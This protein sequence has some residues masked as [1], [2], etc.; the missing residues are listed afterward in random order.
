MRSG[1]PTSATR[2]WS[3]VP[4]TRFGEAVGRRRPPR[5]GNGRDARPAAGPL[6][7]PAGPLQAA[8]PT[9]GGGG[10]PPPRHR[11]GG[12]APRRAACSPRPGPPESA[13][14]PRPGPHPPAGSRSRTVGQQSPATLTSDARLR[15]SAAGG[16][17]R[18]AGPRGAADGRSQGGCRA[19]D[20][21]P[22]RA[23]LRPAQPGAHVPPRR[24][25]AA[26]DGAVARAAPRG[27][28]RRRGL[29]HRRPVPGPGR[30]RA[31]A[32]RHRPV[33]GDAAH[34]RTGAP[35]VQA[36]GLRL[37]LGGRLGRRPH[38]RF[39]PAQ[40]RRPRRLPRRVR[41]GAPPR[42]AAGLAGGGR[43]PTRA[44][45]RFGHR[46]YFGR[47]V[48]WVGARLS[49]AAAYRYLPRSVAY[50]PPTPERCSPAV[51]R[52]GFADVGAARCS[53]RGGPAHHR[54]P[55]PAGTDGQRASSA[56][57]PPGEPTA[58]P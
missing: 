39:R 28:G 41:P 8:P 40:R 2:W 12:P 9:A 3:A 4:D 43:A 15:P 10:D 33:V 34:A 23:P 29:R 54:H 58:A 47:V 57:R 6:P 37:P 52:A 51:E 11:Q 26:P 20:V 25:L 21:R 16:H 30:G 31:A 38:L 42:R 5:A 7:A 36:D 48:P 45:F 32:D 18:E 44:L 27:G 24:G 17:R 1:T 13:R 53:P 35:L 56:R 19:G 49:D 55:E 22:D 50:L 46:I 14:R